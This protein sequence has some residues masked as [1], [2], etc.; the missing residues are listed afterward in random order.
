M[1]TLRS[2]IYFCL[3]QTTVLSAQSKNEFLYG[4]SM[5]PEIETWEQ[6]IKS[7]DYLQKANMNVVRFTESSWGNIEINDGV[8]DFTW[9]HRYLDELQKRGIKV[10]LGTGSYIA[11]QWMYDKYPDLPVELSKGLPNHSMGR[12]AACIFHAGYRE[13]MRKYI[14]RFASEFKDHP[15]IIGWQLDN[16]IDAILTKPDYNK[17]TLNAWT[18]WLKKEFGTIDKFNN[19]LKLHDW[20]LNAHS[21]EQIN[22]P[23]N[24]I[25]G[26]MPQINNLYHRFQRDGINDLFE[27]QKSILRKYYKTQWITTDVMATD[28]A[29]DSKLRTTLDFIGFNYYPTSV[30]KEDEYETWAKQFLFSRDIKT[31]HFIITE[32]RIGVAG[33]TYI[34]TM[35]PSQ[36]KTAMLLPAAFGSTGLLYWT[37]TRNCSGH[38]PLWGGLFDWTGEP[39]PDY[40]AAGEL[41]EIFKKWGNQFINYSVE[42]SIALIYDYEQ[43]MLNNN[44]SFT[45]KNLAVKITSDIVNY[46]SHSGI[47]VDLISPQQAGTIALNKYKCIILPAAK[48]IG[49]T[50]LSKNLKKYV[51]NGGKIII[52]PL[53]NYMSDNGVFSNKGFSKDYEELMGGFV[54]TIR[55]IKPNGDD[56]ETMQKVIISTHDTLN[57]SEGFCEIANKN[58]AGKVLAKFSCNDSALNNKV[59]LSEYSTGK[60][61]TYKLFFWPEHGCG[62]LFKII[63]DNSNPFFY[64]LLPQSIIAVPRT[65]NS[66]FLCNTYFKSYKIILKRDCTDRLSNKKIKMGEYNVLHYETIWLE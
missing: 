9:V 28:Y 66:M 25:E 60:G 26:G 3:L 65:D 39:E 18:A 40:K 63:I 38:W 2:I 61:N 43:T 10:I 33:S 30:N 7:L 31:N 4:I 34:P 14:E 56:G 6:S 5:Y 8:F 15:E 1:I 11:P 44:Y 46:F 47:G 20:G 32:T 21:F 49:N 58:F 50:E 64:G 55:M 45:P 24:E 22:I 57:I 19:A 37:G 13:E 54:Q 12:K 35:N 23:T 41:G 59:A 36:F 51:E 42:A 27:E 48:S 53:C 17:Y 16:E 29:L 52:T 62:E